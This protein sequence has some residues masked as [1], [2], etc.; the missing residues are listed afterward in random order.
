[1]TIPSRGERQNQFVPS[2]EGERHEKSPA[3][4]DTSHAILACA[5]ARSRVR[6]SRSL[7]SR[8]A[9]TAA[10]RRTRLDPSPRPSPPLSTPLLFS[11]GP[12][13]VRVSA[14]VRRRN[15]SAC[16]VHTRLTIGVTVRCV[17]GTRAVIPGVRIEKRGRSARLVVGSRLTDDGGAGKDTWRDKAPGFDAARSSRSCPCLVPLTCRKSA[18]RSKR[19]PR[20]VLVT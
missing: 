16:I 6:F 18:A 19:S 10:P 8:D 2:R 3:G 5:H 14:R 7:F 15:V 13:S 9:H 1:M 17:C 20:N 4:L 12:G 11:P